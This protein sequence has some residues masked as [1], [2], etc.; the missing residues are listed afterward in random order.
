MN[1]LATMASSRTTS[2]VYLSM[3][4]HKQ[5]YVIITSNDHSATVQATIRI[6]GEVL[7]PF[8]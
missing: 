3:T 1:H 5:S 6:I 2:N 7:G 4:F 8:K